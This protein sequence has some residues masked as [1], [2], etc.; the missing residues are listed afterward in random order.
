MNLGENGGVRLVVADVFWLG[1]AGGGGVVSI[2]GATGR[3]AGGRS[4]ARGGGATGRGACDAGEFASARGIGGGQLGPGG[5]GVRCR[6]KTGFTPAGVP[7]I[8]GAAV[9]GAG[10]AGRSSPQLTAAPTG[11]SPPQTEQRALIDTL[12]ILAGSSRNTER[13]SGQETF[14]ET[15]GLVEFANLCAVGRASMSPTAGQLRRQTRSVTW[16]TPSFPTRVR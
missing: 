13:H 15:S 7:A 16:R 12:V 9:R 2:D 1:G 6:E 14:I 11:M 3:G 8:A 4:V 5:A 10:T